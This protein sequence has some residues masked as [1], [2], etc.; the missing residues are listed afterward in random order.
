MKRRAD[1]WNADAYP[2]GSE[3]AWDSTGQ[4]EIYAWTNY[5][6]YKDKALVSLSSILGYMPT[7]PHWGYNGNAR[8]YWDFFYGAA[9]GG[10][11]ERQ[12]HHYGSGLN[13]IPV[14]AQYPRASGRLLSAAHRLRRLDGRALEHR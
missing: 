11:T 8:R 13:A 5:F 4:E 7:V 2:F 9:P 12:I 14:L 6:G 1:R 10:T 3:M